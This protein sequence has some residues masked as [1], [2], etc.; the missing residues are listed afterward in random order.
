MRSSV[1]LERLLT[2]CPGLTV[3]A[4]SRARLL[5]PFEW[6][7]PVPGLSV[8]SAGGRTADAVELFLSRVADGG[9]VVAPR[10]LERVAF[11]CRQLDGM[12][13]AIEL[14]AARLPALGLDGLEAGLTDRLHL[15]AG[16]SRVDDRHR[17]LRSALDWSYAL[18]TEPERALL[19][20]ISVVAGSFSASAAV[21]MFGGWTPVAAGQVPSLLAR[22]ADES[23]LVPVPTL[24]GTRYGVLETIRQYGAA[25]LADA[26]EVDAAHARHLHWCLTAAES[27]GEPTMAG[28][29]GEVWR[30]RFDEISVETRRSLPWAR[31][32]PDQR[33]PA[34]RLSLLMAGL[35]LVRGRPG[36]SQRRFELAAELAPDDTARAFALRLAAGAADGRQFGNEALRLRE[37]S[38]EAAL[39]AG[40]RAG[41]AMDLARA[42]ELVGRGPGIMAV[43]P[44][45]GELERL[46]S[47]ARSLAGGDA[48]AESRILTA[49]AFARDSA[50]PGGA[51]A[52][53]AGPGRAH[54]AGDPLG[55]SA[56]L[57]LLTAAQLA[58]GQLPEALDSAV[59]RTEL[60]AQV[61]VTADSAFEFFDSYQMGSQCALA[62]GDLGEARRLGEGLLDLPFYREE[63]HLATSRLIVVGLLEGT[64]DEALA[65]AEQFRAGWE[66]AGRP[67]QGN[68]RPATYAAA[69]IQALRGDDTARADWMTVT[70]TLEAPV[71]K[72]PVPGRLGRDPD[73]PFGRF[74][75]ALVLLHR[76]LAAEA[77][78]LLADPPESLVGDAGGM[79]RP[80]YAS[81]WAEAAVL[82]GQP[83]AESG[84]AAPSSRQWA[85]RSPRPWCSGR[86]AGPGGRRRTGPRRAGRRGLGPAVPGCAL[87]V[88]AHAGDA[89]RGRPRAGPRRARR[90]G[91]RAYGLASTMMLNGVRAATRTRE[92]PAARSTCSSRCG[93]AWA[94]RPSAP[95]WASEDGVQIT[96]ERP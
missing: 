81:V 82:S 85:T 88:G 55:V 39:R 23:L 91:R 31:H 68:L 1:L 96:V 29:E 35:S 66:R 17:S 46:L 53:R 11:L 69:T 32:V 83:D 49:E 24:L 3:L 26:G 54:L 50:G 89:R 62:A 37:L 63:D 14:A 71:R 38:A 7:Y 44:G 19:R 65:Q 30:A 10:E 60:L 2:A 43:P 93:P 20:R 4:T 92:K 27:L 22:L 16:G 58:D 70:T 76:G 28:E 56:A 64:W 57:D 75:D 33:D 48:A 78:E 21:E 61:P 12:A 36:E 74:F 9:S 79:W 86:R 73:A 87:P 47:M 8:A 18:L 13:L 42:A 25:L 84:W 95:S 40:D 52:C 77:V 94:P 51:F 15:L 45:P 41:A 67:L 5:L 59:R 34:Y 72:A 80:W 90:D 6:S